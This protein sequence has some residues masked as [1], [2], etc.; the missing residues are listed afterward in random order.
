MSWRRYA[1][2][3]LCEGDGEKFRQEYPHSIESAF[4]AS[5]KPFF[6]VSICAKKIMECKEPLMVGDLEVVYDDSEAYKQRLQ[7]EDVNFVDLRSFV[8]EVR[9]VENP[10]GYV[11]I[12]DE[13]KK[14]EGYYRFCSSF[15]VAE[16]IEQGD[17]TAGVVLDRESMKEVMT[18]HGHLDADLIAQEQFKIWWFLGKDCHF[19]T[20]KNNMG[21]TVVNKAFDLGVPQFHRMSFDSGRT[22]VSKDNF[23]FKTSSTTKM[24]AANLLKEWIREDEWICVD[25]AFWLET[26]TFVRDEK[27]RISA[28]G[29]HRGSSNFDDRIISRAINCIA[30]QWLPPFIPIKEER[31]SA[32][33]FISNRVE[34]R[35]KF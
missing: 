35:T 16:G 2:D 17:Y 32:R 11:S 19:A 31:K 9:F 27:G 1:I 28:E 20:E 4:L 22:K 14:N 21:V 29:K 7:E 10:R 26:L 3:N 30:H 34:R 24:H 33:S 18:W 12:W 5:G 6:N 15:D 13:I 8:K 25:K 23:G